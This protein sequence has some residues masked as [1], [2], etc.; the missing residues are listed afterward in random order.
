MVGAAACVRT[1]PQPGRAGL[2]AGVTLAECPAR[3]GR[4]KTCKTNP[5]QGR[6]GRHTKLVPST[7]AP[8]PHGTFAGSGACRGPGR[9]MP[10]GPSTLRALFT[11]Q[12]TLP[13][14]GLVTAPRW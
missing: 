3:P 2:K 6:G 5:S 7:G 14:L 9:E 12:G 4:I 11:N 13:H 10:E 1:W 8:G